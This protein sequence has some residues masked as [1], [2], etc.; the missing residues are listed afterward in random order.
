MNDA[1]LWKIFKEKYISFCGAKVMRD[2][3]GISKGFGFI[4]FRA[5]D[6]AEKALHEMNG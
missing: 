3:T 4:Q 6:E 1:D 5:R 2:T